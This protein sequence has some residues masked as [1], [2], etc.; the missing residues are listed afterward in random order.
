V[1][2]TPVPP[3]AQEEEAEEVETEDLE[4]MRG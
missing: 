3:V 1:K 4:A 2:G